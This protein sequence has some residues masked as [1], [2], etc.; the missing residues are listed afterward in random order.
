MFELVIKPSLFPTNPP[1][2]FAVDVTFTAE[3]EFLISPKFAAA[4]PPADSEYPV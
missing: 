4:K 1:T 2:T 3:E